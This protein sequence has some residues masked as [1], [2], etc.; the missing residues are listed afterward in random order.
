MKI[1]AGRERL[2]EG[3]KMTE[4]EYEIRWA[5][6]PVGVGLTL[7]GA[8]EVNKGKTWKQDVAGLIGY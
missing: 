7:D 8:V 4:W 5:L 2:E 6:S 1:R 3:R